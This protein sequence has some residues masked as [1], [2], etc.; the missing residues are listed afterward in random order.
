MKKKKKIL[1]SQ[2]CELQFG[3]SLMK[4]SYTTVKD[5][6]RRNGILHACNSLINRVHA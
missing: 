4:D 6:L 2:K 1:K 5:S 3:Y